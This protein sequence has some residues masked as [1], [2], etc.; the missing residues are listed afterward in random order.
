MN[1]SLTEKQRLF[2]IA[3]VHNGGNRT[4]AA[5]SAGYHAKRANQSGYQ[6]LTSPAVQAAIRKE[7]EDLLV[8][9]VGIGAKVLV[10]L[11][12]KSKSDSV[13]L[14]AATALL[15]RGGLQL[16]RQT[17]HKHTLEDH[18][19]DAELREHIK[20]LTAELGLDAKIVNAKVIE[21]DDAEPRKTVAPT[22]K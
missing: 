16:V 7:A 2:A 17:E 14:Q 3:Y 22:A 20:R 19:T 11:A 8:S 13:R 6:A 15:D 18:R 9:N 12:T 1:Q 4:Q 5:I 21:H 10:E